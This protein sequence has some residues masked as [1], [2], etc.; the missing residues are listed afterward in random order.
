MKLLTKM[1]FIHYNDFNVD[2]L[3]VERLRDV[4]TSK[5]DIFQKMSVSYKYNNDS[6]TEPLLLQGP[7][8]ITTKRGLHITFGTK[9]S[10]DVNVEYDLDNEEHVAYIRVLLDIYYCVML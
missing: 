5:G 2:C 7:E 6:V 1:N 10:S 9:R 8:V 4:R 3:V